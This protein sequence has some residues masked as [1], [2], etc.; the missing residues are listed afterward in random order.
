MVNRNSM[1]SIEDIH[2]MVLKEI[3]EQNE[4]LEPKE[5]YEPIWYTLRSG[6]KRLRPIL[7]LLGCQMFSDNLAAALKPA[8]GIE[9]FHNFTLLH[10]DI[11]DKAFLRRN[12]PT[13]HIKWDI[14]R[15]ILSGD[16]MAIQANIFISSCKADV[17]P[18]VLQV[19]NKTA[20]EVCEGQQYD[21]NFEIRDE[22]TVAE[23]MNMIK[24]K[25][26]VLLAGSLKIGAIIGGSGN[27]Q[28]D[29]VYDFGYDMGMAFQLQDDYLDTFGSPE[30]FGKKI[31]GDIMA[32]KKTFLLIKAKQNANPKQ[33]EE[34]NR[35]YSDEE[36]DPEKKIPAV[37]KIF[38]DLEID[39]LTREQ[40]ISYSRKALDCLENIDTEIERKTELKNF[41]NKLI[42]RVS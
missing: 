15:A 18:Q 16:A 8:L 23:Y 5:L 21:L 38:K 31:G 3:E 13:V 7:V 28:A 32:N 4:V 41:T 40:V 24:L 19:F 42:N 22:V 36:H 14:N 2:Q 9:L 33:L 20:L 30:T 34:L 1:K 29:L 17:L 39:R 10:D 35:W 37:Q 11:M 25:T 12:Q 27:E 6:G 26:A